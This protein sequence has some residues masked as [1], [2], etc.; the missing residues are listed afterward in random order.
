MAQWRPYARLIWLLP[1]RASFSQTWAVMMPPRPLS[2]TSPKLG[3]SKWA[4]LFAGPPAGPP[5]ARRLH[6]HDHSVAH[7]DGRVTAAQHSG[8]PDPRTIFLLAAGAH[9]PLGQFMGG[10]VPAILAATPDQRGAITAGGR[11]T[12]AQHDVL[13]RL[14]LA[15]AYLTLDR[16][17]AF[18]RILQI[19]QD[20]A[21]DEPFLQMASRLRRPRTAHVPATA[22]I[23]PSPATARFTLQNRRSLI[24]WLRA[25]HCLILAPDTADFEDTI[26]GLARATRMIIA[27]STQAGLLGLCQ[28][29]TQILEIAPE[30]W[31]DR[32]IRT[33]CLALGLDWHLFLATPPSYSLLRPPPLGMRAALGFEIPIAGLSRALVTL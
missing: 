33:A 29:G 10:G 8:P 21:G 12:P 7:P 9:V 5:A 23:L 2:R 31:T 28:P 16:P 30:G 11:L 13:I 1:R 14:G 27:D 32:H 25:R 6:A 15:E 24:A 3:G 20:I 19:T 17:T 22:A 4:A 26:S 18:A